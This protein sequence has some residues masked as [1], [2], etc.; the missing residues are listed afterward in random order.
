[1]VLAC[2]LFTACL[3]KTDRNS[4]TPLS[5]IHMWHHRQQSF[6]LLWE[7]E[8]LPSDPGWTDSPVG[9]PS[10]SWAIMS[11]VPATCPVGCTALHKC[12]PVRLQ[13]QRHSCAIYL[14]TGALQTDFSC[15]YPIF[16]LLWGNYAIYH[17]A[18]VKSIC[19]SQAWC[20]F[21]GVHIAVD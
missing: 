6:I 5:L 1:M 7:A 12:L 21:W 2:L 8:S 18:E 9:T 3:F 15:T 11:F 16:N 13:S 10:F 17:S 20:K 14:I 19:K 4:P